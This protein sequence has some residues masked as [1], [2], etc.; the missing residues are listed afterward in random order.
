MTERGPTRRHLLLA[1]I[2]G[3]FALR[4]AEAGPLFW[5]RLTGTWLGELTYL[6]GDLRP[7]IQTYHAVLDLSMNNQELSLTEFKFYPPGTELARDIAGDDL[8]TDQGVEVI[9]EISGTV[10]NNRWATRT[11][12]VYEL[13]DDQTLVRHLSSDGNATPRYV[14]YWTMTSDRTLIVTNLGILSTR[15]EANDYDHPVEPW[16]PNARLGELKGCSIFRYLRV[17]ETDREQQLDRLRT[18]YNVKKRLDRRTSRR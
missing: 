2:A 4:A 11:D 12:G 17:K 13:V 10:A 3:P 7:I 1:A 16:R 15:L 9:S 14:T 6:D 8:P 18:E 5:S